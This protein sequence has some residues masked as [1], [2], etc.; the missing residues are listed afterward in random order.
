[1][2]EDNAP[3]LRGDP[4]EAAAAEFRGILGSGGSVQGSGGADPDILAQLRGLDRWATAR[5]ELGGG[6]WLS[7]AV[8]GGAEHFIQYA[9]S[10]ERVIKITHPGQF[11]LQMS[12]ILPRGVF[13]RRLNVAI[14]LRPATPLEYLDRL[15]LHNAVFADDVEFLGLVKHKDR[16]SFVISQIFL[17]GQRPTNDQIAAH[18]SET[19]FRRLDRENAYYREQDHLAVFDA[20]AR[21][22]VLT[23]DIPVPFDVIP[24]IVSGRMDALLGI[25]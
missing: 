1:M 13:P 7:T 14:A 6:A 18:M 23:D 3:D 24:Q 10:S 9:P 17:K 21:N 11:G 12:M 22:F 25:W 2:H 20:H 5:G 19:G 15:A 8:R 16:W 4:P